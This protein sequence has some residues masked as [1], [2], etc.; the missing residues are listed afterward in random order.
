MST[1]IDSLS[2]LSDAPFKPKNHLISY[3]NNKCPFRKY[4]ADFE[5]I[6]EWKVFI[7]QYWSWVIRLVDLL[8][9]S[10]ASVFMFTLLL[11]QT[12]RRSLF[13]LY[14]FSYCRT[15]SLTDTRGTQQ[16]KWMKSI[17]LPTAT[18]TE[19]MLSSHLYTVQEQSRN[20]I[21][22]VL[23]I[24]VFSHFVIQIIAKLSCLFLTCVRF[25]VILL[26]VRI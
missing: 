6:D 19:K 3:H 13:V 20:K 14:V 21:R 9:L 4:A 5:I 25:Q 23:C 26:G 18:S 16:S 17:G 15:Y 12:T 2:S 1:Q 8:L 10:F 24:Y 22:E 7:C 11:S